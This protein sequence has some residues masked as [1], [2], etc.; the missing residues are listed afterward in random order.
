MTERKMVKKRWIILRHS[1]K[2]PKVKVPINTDFALVRMLRESA[3]LHPDAQLTVIR[4]TY[5]GQ[6]WVDDGHEFV[7]THDLLSAGER[8]AKAGADLRKK[9]EARNADF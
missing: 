4:L 8:G 2:V 6:L 3:R 5:D 7:N 9:L 1:G